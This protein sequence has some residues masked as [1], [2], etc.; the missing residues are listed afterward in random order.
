MNCPYCALCASVAQKP[1]REICGFSSLCR[2]TT[3]GSGSQSSA[4][5][6][7]ARGNPAHAGQLQGRLNEDPN[8]AAR[9]RRHSR[10]TQ[11]RG[12]TYHLSYLTGGGYVELRR[13]RD[14]PGWR[15]DRPRAHGEMADDIVD[16]RLTNRGLWLYD[17]KVPPDPRVRF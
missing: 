9:A 11:P 7:G 12:P 14:Q 15:T 3:H 6:R 17:G 5:R 4:A 16:V 10:L 8:P 13:R 2:R 1:I